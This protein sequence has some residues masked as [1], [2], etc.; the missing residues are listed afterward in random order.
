MVKPPLKPFGRKLAEFLPLK[1]AE[2]MLLDSCRCG[3][4]AIISKQRP[5]ENDATIQN[6]VRASFV[7]FLALGGDEYAPVHEMGVQFQGAYVEGDLNMESVILP[8]NL[9][10]RLCNLK[11]II[12]RNSKVHGSVSFHGSQIGCLIA[13]RMVCSNSIFLKD[14]FIASGSVQLDKVQ[15]NGDFDCTNGLFDGKHGTALSCEEAV[16]NGSV[17]LE[18]SFYALGTVSLRSTQIACDL[19]CSNGVFDGNGN[20]ALMGS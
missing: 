4:E 15:I 17:F 6:T 1:P 18:G 14:G 9:A 7:R 11:N 10:L 2:K 5:S 19:N 16:I 13:D 8:Y 3:H 12:L 20:Y